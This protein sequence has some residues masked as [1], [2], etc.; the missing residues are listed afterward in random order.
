MLHST[1]NVVWE[2]PAGLT[3]EVHVDNVAGTE[4]WPGPPRG[5]SDRIHQSFSPVLLLVGIYFPEVPQSAK[6]YTRAPLQH[7]GGKKANLNV[8]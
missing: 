3:A 4:P 2:R 1:K 8:R 5:E 7:S 6:T